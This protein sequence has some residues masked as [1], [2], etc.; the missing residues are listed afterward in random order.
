VHVMTRGEAAQQ[1]AITLGA[2]SAS[3]AYDAPPEPLDSAILFAPVGDLVPVALEALDRGGILSIAGIHLSDVPV[4][5]YERDLFY[6]REIRSVA[7]NTRA[8][9]EAFLRFA[10]E[11]HLQVTTHEYP[12]DQAQVALQ[13]LKSGC[14]DGAAVLRN[15]YR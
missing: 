14:F 4:L 1:L 13:D 11:H 3:G 7:A 15:P 9:G 10:A 6:E 5:N 12:L 8:D 2:T